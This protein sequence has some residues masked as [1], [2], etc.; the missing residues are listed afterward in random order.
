MDMG[1]IL[2][3]YRVLQGKS[4]CVQVID[5]HPQPAVLAAVE[6]ENQPGKIDERGFIALHR[7]KPH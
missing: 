3:L 4:N 6:A 5:Q 2:N 7:P 1:L